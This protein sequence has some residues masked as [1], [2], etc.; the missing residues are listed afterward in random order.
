MA[1]FDQRHPR[2]A[3]EPEA[4]C[5]QSQREEIYVKF[6]VLIGRRVPSG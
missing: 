1:A 5:Q 2:D 6:T 3:Q 4:I